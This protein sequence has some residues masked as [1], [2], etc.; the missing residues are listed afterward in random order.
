MVSMVSAVPAGAVMAREDVFGMVRPS[1]ATIGTIIGVVRFPGKP[2][3]EC[4]ST[5][6]WTSTTT[7]LRAR[8]S[9]WSNG[10]VAH[11]VT[12]DAR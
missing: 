5:T 11:A 2:P 9:R 1:E 10:R 7:Y 8:I 6:K 12:K 3:T 4:L